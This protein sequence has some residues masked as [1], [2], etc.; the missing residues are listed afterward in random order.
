M[1]KIVT[2]EHLAVAGPEKKQ[3]AKVDD[4]RCQRLE[5]SRGLPV[6][7]PPQRLVRTGPRRFDDLF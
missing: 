2:I 7:P 3:D 4:E 6:R 1:S 5:A